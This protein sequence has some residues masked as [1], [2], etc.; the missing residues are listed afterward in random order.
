[1]PTYVYACKDCGH[2]FEKYQSFQDEAL[3]ECPTCEGQLRKVFNSVGIVFKGSGFYSTDSGA[4]SK[5][6]ATSGDKD[7]AAGSSASSS[8]RKSG[9]S[10]TSSSSGADSHGS[11]APASSSGTSKAAASNAA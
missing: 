3:S 6:T 11:S 4:R 2:Q 9:D 5:T 7:K 1:M 10:S 8:D